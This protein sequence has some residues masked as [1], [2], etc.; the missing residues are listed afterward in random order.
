MTQCN[1][2]SSKMN[3]C[4][5]ETD[6]DIEVNKK[7]EIDPRSTS[8]NSYFPNTSSDE[9]STLEDSDLEV[10]KNN[11][12]KDPAPLEKITVS[13]FKEN[14]SIPS[15]QTSA[16]T[17]SASEEIKTVQK[18]NT[19]Q[20]K[21]TTLSE[22]KGDFNI[23]EDY[24]F[25]ITCDSSFEDEFS[26]CE[27]GAVIELNKNINVSQIYSSILKRKDNNSNETKSLVS[28]EVKDELSSLRQIPTY[29]NLQRV[30]PPNGLQENDNVQTYT[31][32]QDT[33][34]N[35]N[36]ITQSDIPQQNSP[37]HISQTDNFQD[38]SHQ[39]ILQSDIFQGDTPQRNLVRQNICQQNPSK[40]N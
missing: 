26:D 15:L 4:D 23:N 14:S 2:V 8:K 18:K 36:N 17:V 11:L 12:P 28:G 29:N 1:T 22:N 19:N 37:Q 38:I 9:F 30:T 6:S 39:N 35:N 10:D 3:Y 34:I 20:I 40:C 21:I 31:F 33:I 13:L 5:S 24:N 32:Q 27:A 16:E 7:D 25:K